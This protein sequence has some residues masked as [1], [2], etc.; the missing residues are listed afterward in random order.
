MSQ[1]KKLFLHYMFSC[2]LSHAIAAGQRS[3]H[4]S[5][6]MQLYNDHLLYQAS[7]LLLQLELL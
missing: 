3:I 7:H 1:S 6:R 5:L 4:H 2:H